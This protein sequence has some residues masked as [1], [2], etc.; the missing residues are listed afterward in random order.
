MAI[1]A[2]YQGCDARTDYWEA[3]PGAFPA[4]SHR[5][6]GKHEGETNHVERWLGSLRARVSRLVRKADAFS[7]NVE[8]HLDEECWWLTFTHSP[9]RVLSCV[10]D[11][12]DGDVPLSGR[13]SG[14]AAQRPET[15]RPISAPHHADPPLW[16]SPVLKTDRLCCPRLC[17]GDAGDWR[18]CSSSLYDGANQK[19]GHSTHQRNGQTTTHISHSFTP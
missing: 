8:N 3:Y 15:H 10:Q 1:P 9:P 17:V 6:C 11:G 2:D 13:T 16:S 4:C 7:R 14:N 18:Q 12:V 19:H 5:A